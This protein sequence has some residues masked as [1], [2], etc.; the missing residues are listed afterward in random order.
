MASPGFAPS[1]NPFETGLISVEFPEVVPP[2][3]GQRPL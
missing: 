2:G 3:R 1:G